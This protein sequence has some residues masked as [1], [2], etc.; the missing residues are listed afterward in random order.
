MKFARIFGLTKRSEPLDE[1]I[2]QFLREYSSALARLRDIR[3]SFDFAADEALTDA[4]IFEENAALTVIDR[5]I[6]EA[7]SQGISIDF[8]DFD[9]ISL[10]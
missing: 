4:L 9:K 7:K 8:V 1:K 6:R 2:E 3:N 10:E 5:L